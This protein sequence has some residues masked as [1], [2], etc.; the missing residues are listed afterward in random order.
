MDATAGIPKLV[1]A[2]RGYCPV[3]AESTTFRAYN[4]WFRDHL[5]CARCGSIPRERALAVVIDNLAPEWRTL[6]I[7]ESSPCL[8]GLSA[9]LSVECSHYIPTQFFPGVQPGTMHEGYLCEN[10]ERQTF[11]DESFDLVVTQDVFEHIFDPDAAHREIWRT[12]KPG[13]MHIFTTPI[14]G[15]MHTSF[16]CAER[17]P[18]G[19]IRH[20]RPPEYHGNPIDESGSLVTFLWGYD[21]ADLVV[22][23]TCFD[24]EVRRFNDHHQGIVGP[25][26]EVMICRKRLAGATC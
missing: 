25:Y 23:A 10:L 21:I 5:L 8:R 15:N 20:L 3:C 11:A 17:S 6:H 19:E 18:D 14:A 13:G 12:L 4:D 22:A 1:A 2:W 26:T 9:K 7:H 16:R 24:V